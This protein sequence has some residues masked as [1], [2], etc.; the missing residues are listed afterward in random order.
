M[1]VPMPLPVAV[2]VARLSELTKETTTCPAA[3]CPTSGPRS[4]LPASSLLQ[5][6]IGLAS[7]QLPHHPLP[8]LR[9]SIFGSAPDPGSPPPL[10]VW[11]HFRVCT[12]AVPHSPLWGH[13]R[14]CT[15][16]WLPPISNRVGAFSGLQQTLALPHAPCWGIFWSALWLSLTSN[17]VSS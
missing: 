4:C 15:R 8:S 11:G 5:I 13:F 3:T 2:A 10:T 1:P 7:P 12:L 14:V 17:H 6:R 16:P 9:G